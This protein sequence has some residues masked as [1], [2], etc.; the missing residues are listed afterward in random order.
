[1]RCP[2]RSGHDRGMFPLPA[3]HTDLA[4][5]RQADLIVGPSVTACRPTR[6]VTSQRVHRLRAATRRAVRPCL[7]TVRASRED[8]RRGLRCDPSAVI[9]S[10]PHEPMQQR[11]RESAAHVPACVDA[12]RG[13]ASRLLC[14]SSV[15]AG[16]GCAMSGS[17]T[18]NVD[19]LSSSDST[20]IVPPIR[21]TSSREMY[22]PRPLPLTPRVMFASAR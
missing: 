13:E 11:Q 14:R 16:A 18:T 20:K 3:I 22:R 12:E 1:M 15:Q 17:V 10:R 7:T 21:L 2:S 6:R 9:P 5:G 4:R 19:P 8:G